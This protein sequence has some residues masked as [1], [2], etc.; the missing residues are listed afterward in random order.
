M[1]AR[2]ALRLAALLLLRSQARGIVRRD[3]V[4]PQLYATTPA[5]YQ[6]AVQRFFNWSASHDTAVTFLISGG[7]KFFSPP[8]VSGPHYAYE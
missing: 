2:P 6:S 7:A 4:D 3:D 5:A 8:L 1:A